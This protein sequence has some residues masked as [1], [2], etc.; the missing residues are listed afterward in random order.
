[1]RGERDDSECLECGEKVRHD[2]NAIICIEI[3][4]DH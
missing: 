3:F 4:I 2:I 1:M